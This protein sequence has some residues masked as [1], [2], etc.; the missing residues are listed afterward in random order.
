MRIATLL[1]SAALLA[2]GLLAVSA[3]SPA[4]AAAKMGAF[5][6]CYANK[7]LL[8]GIV[9]G[10]NLVVVTPKK[11]MSGDVSVTQ[12]INPPLDVKLPVQ[13]HYRDIAKGRHAAKLASPNMPGRHITVALTATANWKAAVATYSL[14]L[15]TPQPPKTGKVTLN[16]VPCK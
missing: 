6:V 4:G 11:T 15:D 13:G 9:M 2:V 1:R 5:H 16:A 7:P 8:G 3:T 14:W 12:A 10:L